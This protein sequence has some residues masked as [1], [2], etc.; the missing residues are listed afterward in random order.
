MPESD[1]QRVARALGEATGKRQQAIEALD[2]I[3]EQI[4]HLIELGM[5]QTPRMHALKEKAHKARQDLARFTGEA[6]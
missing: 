6:A 5:V 4:A 1:E 3:D 2:R